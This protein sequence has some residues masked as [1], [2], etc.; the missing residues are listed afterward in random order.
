MLFKL[1]NAVDE[2]SREEQCGFRKGEDT[3]TMFYF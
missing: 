3:L 1:S 2:I